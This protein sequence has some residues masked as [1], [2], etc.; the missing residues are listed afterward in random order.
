MFQIRKAVGC[1]LN[2]IQ[3][4][5]FALGENSKTHFFRPVRRYSDTSTVLWC[6]STVLMV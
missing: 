4:V 2:E 1:V 5:N 3:Y 6:F